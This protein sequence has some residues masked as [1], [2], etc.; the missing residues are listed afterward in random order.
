MTQTI[1]GVH[2]MTWETPA[3][4]EFRMDAEMSAYQDDFDGV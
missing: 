2:T 1:R 3:F 4:V